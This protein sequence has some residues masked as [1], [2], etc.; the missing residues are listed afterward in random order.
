[1]RDLDARLSLGDGDEIK[2]GGGVFVRPARRQSL[3]ERAA[4]A[5]AGDG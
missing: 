4:G 3:G 5:Q 1:M 2:V